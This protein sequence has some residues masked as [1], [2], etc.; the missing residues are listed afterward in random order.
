MV[1]INLDFP[2]YEYVDPSGRPRGFDVELLER[3]AQ[4]TDLRIQFR[5]GPWDRIRGD[6][7]AGRIDLLA[8]M[9]KSA[10]RERYAA[11]SS[12]TLLIFYGIF[13]RND[14]AGVTRLEDLKGRRVLVENGSQM[15]EHLKSMG[16][17]AETEPVDSEPAA[18]RLLAGGEGDAAIV[19]LITGAMQMRDGGIT[20]VRRVGDAIYS[21]ELCF[22]VRKQDQ[23]LV[24]RLNTGLAILNQN[25]EYARIYQKWFGDL[26][27]SENTL[28]SILRRS[29]W[30]LAPLLGIALGAIT[31]TWFLRRQVLSRTRE[32]HVLNRSLREKERFLE[33]IVDHLPVAV[34]GKDP[35]NNFAYTVWNKRSEELFGLKAEEALGRSDGDFEP[36]E[37]AALF[38]RSDEACI[39]ERRP[40]DIP[41]DHSYSRSHEVVLLH[42]VKVPIF[43]EEGEPWMVLAISEDVT[44]RRRT[45][46]ALLRSQAN[47]AEAQRI[48]H[49]G[50]WEWSPHTDQV[51]WSDEL[52]RILDVDPQA[53]RPSL[54]L[55]LRLSHPADRSLLVGFVKTCLRSRREGSLDH[56]MMLPRKGLRHLRTTLE[57]RL[58]ADGGIL[59]VLG[60]TQDVTDRRHAEEA[61]RQAQKLEGLGVLAGGIAHDFNNLLTAI[62]ANL[63]LAQTTIAEDS[64]TARYLKSMES[65]VVRAADLTRQM[66]AYSGR[67]TFVIQSL[68]LNR[69]AE[70]ITELL[71][72]SIPKKVE[73]RFEL[74]PELPPIEADIAQI[75]QVIMN[76]VTNASEA[77]G[78]QEGVITLATGTRLLDPEGILQEFP[79]QELHPGTFVMLAV[80]DTGCGMDER[81]KERLFEPFFTTKF[82]GR[83]LGLSA[84][85]GILKGHH[86]GIQI[87]TEPGKGS[88]FRVFFPAHSGAVAAPAAVAD[89]EDE[90][91][92][93]RG[94]VLLVDDE[95]VVRASTRTM[96]EEL[97]YKV[98]E[99]RD[100]VEALERFEEHAGHLAVVLLDLTMPRLDGHETLRE[101]RQ[102]VPEVRVILCSGYHEQEAR[103]DIRSG[104]PVGFLHKPFSLADLRTALGKL[105]R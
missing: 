81:T 55:V 80:A 105:P 16:F 76:L 88:A 18:L 34:F 11:F 20:N 63:N 9:L 93:L 3:A 32:L 58:E 86:A 29:L 8:G 65:T 44:L 43:D 47:L 68:D 98:I 69:V 14:S 66:L 60:I 100:G 13:V 84:L 97:G 50:S 30:V 2:P 71:R 41:D 104:D 49:L 37:S 83:G 12:P 67:G 72:A 33:A 91:N 7:A 56:R 75:Q 19:P 54:S 70:E 46:A 27:R 74:R 92:R 57:V 45:E 10:E 6:R 95:A 89:G 38:R 25:G 62:L 53:T 40:I 21:R 22:A 31:W 28:P 99:A 103:R 15:H 102:R 48:T 82:S 35:R 90:P 39:R 26:E 52:Y 1:G 24:E 64:R 61:L 101:L 4:A 73:I 5:P 51:H 94:T 78:D 79:G 87:D 77:I 42:T 36:P 85:L 17:S 59:Q 23:A 96:L